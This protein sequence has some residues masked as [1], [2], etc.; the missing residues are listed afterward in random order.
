MLHLFAQ[1]FLPKVGGAASLGEHVHVPKV[2]V[3]SGDIS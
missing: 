3:L 1:N 2:T